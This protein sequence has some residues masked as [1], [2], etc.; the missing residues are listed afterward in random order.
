LLACGSDFGAQTNAL[1]SLQEC[2]KPGVSNIRPAGRNRPVA[3][4][5][6]ARG[7]IL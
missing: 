1:M 3:R 7:M 2:V 5:N 4:L 6:P